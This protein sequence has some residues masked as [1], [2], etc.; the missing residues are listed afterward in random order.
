MSLLWGHVS[1]LG[2]TETCGLITVHLV[3]PFTT[4]E[5]SG[6]SGLRV[7]GWVMPPACFPH[8]PLRNWGGTFTPGGTTSARVG[9]QPHGHFAQ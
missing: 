2:N 3:L 6:L 1:A 8:D 7:P 4:F 5:N 9:S